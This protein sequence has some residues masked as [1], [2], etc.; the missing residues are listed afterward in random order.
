MKRDPTN[1]L[2]KSIDCLN[3]GGILLYPSD[4]LW[5]LGCDA[6]NQQAIQKLYAIKKRSDVKPLIILVS[7]IR[8]LQN[9][10][11]NVPEVVWD[12]L[13]FSTEPLTI[14][15]PKASSALKHL[16]AQDGSIA[17]RF[18]QSGWIQKLIEKYKKP[19]T[20]SSANLSGGASPLKLSDIS[21]DIKQT[22]DYIVEEDDS[23]M[24]MTGRASRLLKI[25]ENGEIKILR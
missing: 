23:N 20:S 8:M 2:Q 5:G 19:I 1:V 12:I 4:S 18:V 9:V 16:E 13:E 25:G 7:S 14:I 21:S 17:V 10:V 22:A 6:T 11:K 15:Y 3:G 24:S